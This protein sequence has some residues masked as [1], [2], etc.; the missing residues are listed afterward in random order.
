M[1]KTD[2]EDRN[3]RWSVQG[4]LNGIKATF[5]LG[6]K[7]IKSPGGKEPITV[8]S[9]ALAV[10]K[11]AAVEKQYDTRMTQSEGKLRMWRNDYKPLALKKLEENFHPLNFARMRLMVHVSS[12]TMVRVIKDISLTYAKPPVR[13]LEEDE[14]EVEPVIPSKLPPPEEE[15]VEEPVDEEET[16]DEPEAEPEDQELLGLPPIKKPKKPAV[17]GQETLYTGEPDVDALIDV[18]DL[19]G[20]DIKKDG[21]LDKLLKHAPLDATMET[22]EWFAR[23]LPCV[24]VRPFVRYPNNIEVS[25][26]KVDATGVSTT[27]TEMKPDPATAKLDYIIY[28]PDRADVVEDPENPGCALAFYYWSEEWNEKA[29]KVRVI[30]FFTNEQYMKLDDQW[31]VLESAP[32]ELEELPVVPMRLGKPVNCYYMDGEG[33]DL[34]EGTLELAV[35]KTIQNARARD[36]GFK[37]LAFTGTQ[38]DEVDA[39]QVMGGPVPLF[40]GDAG[41]VQVLDMQTNLKDWT[42]LCRERGLELAAKYGISAAEYKAEGA[43]QSGFA[44][45]LDYDKVLKENERTRK[46]FSEFEKELYKKTRRVLEI[47]P[48]T[49]IGDLPDAEYSVDFAEPAFSEDPETEAKTDAQE[50]KLNITSIVNVLKRKNPDLSEVELVKLAFKYKKINETLL[51]GSSMKLIDFL[52]GMPPEQG[53]GGP[54]GPPGRG[55]PPKPGGFGG[56]KPPL[57]GEEEPEVE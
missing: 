38:A 37:Q 15:P 13:S 2:A 45:R 48:V 33:D 5:G 46:F 1:A 42:E 36:T 3:R 47:S 27:T 57:P 31:R 51:P 7:V 9:R 18:L 44:K 52:S 35:L 55:G 43:P 34:F 25:T 14:P 20:G 53:A 49:D 21:P 11:A 23:F 8:V 41:S 32:N 29:Q 17:P 19:E 16:D 56:P 39:D 10:A 12:N 40:A 50:I 28:T 24:W 54:G 6:G 4:M 30:N 26:T 22:V